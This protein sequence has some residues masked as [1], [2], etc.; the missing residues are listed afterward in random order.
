MKY[1]KLEIHFSKSSPQSKYDAFDDFVNDNYPTDM[2][3]V[4]DEMPDD[5]EPTSDD[6]R[7]MVF[8]V[9]DVGYARECFSNWAKEAGQKIEK[10]IET[11][12]TK[13]EFDKYNEC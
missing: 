6:S 4:V 1:T 13:K 9:D 10:I 8:I 5:E 2:W 3:A 12:S 11:K 7:M